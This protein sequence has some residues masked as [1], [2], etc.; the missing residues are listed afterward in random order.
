MKLSVTISEY[1]WPDGPSR[2]AAHVGDVAHAA[3]ELGLDTVWVPDHL[4]Q[5][6]PGTSLED[7]VLEATL[8]EAVS[9]AATIPTSR[10]PCSPTPG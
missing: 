3:D 5:G 7:E 10:T 8:G 6:V 4:L 9:A 1:T 2:L